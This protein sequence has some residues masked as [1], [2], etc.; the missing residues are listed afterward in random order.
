MLSGR[1]RTRC[2]VILRLYSSVFLSFCLLLSLIIQGWFPVDSLCD[3]FVDLSLVTISSARST[4]S[5]CT[6]G[7]SYGNEWCTK[8]VDYKT[9]AHKRCHFNSWIDM[10]GHLGGSCKTTFE[11]YEM[12]REQ[13][14]VGGRVGLQQDP[15]KMA[16]IY[17]AHLNALKELC[18][19]KKRCSRFGIVLEGDALVNSRFQQYHP[20]AFSALMLNMSDV[21]VFNLGPTSPVYKD[22]HRLNGVEQGKCF[23]PHRLGTWGAVAVGYNLSTACSRHFFT[24]Q[25]AM[26]GCVPT[27]IGLYSG[28]GGYSAVD[29]TLTFFPVN[30]DLSSTNAA[31]DIHAKLTLTYAENLKLWGEFKKKGFVCERT[32]F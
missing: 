21:S 13:F 14:E 5:A 29:S 15:R 4:S 31:D 22:R 2:L 1:R 8:P 11:D 24:T 7:V 9:L 30:P 27:D 19:A 3:T 32:Q 23:V 20:H 10:L 28:A 12:Y 16:A 6:P 25:E 26:I 17:I 18:S